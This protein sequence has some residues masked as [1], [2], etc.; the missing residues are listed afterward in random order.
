[1]AVFDANLLVALAVKAPWSAKARELLIQ[2]PKP[3]APAFLQIE[4]ANAL[5]R[6]VREGAI[7]PVDAIHAVRAIPAL[8]HL[9][10]DAPLAEPALQI[11]IAAK[12]PVYDCL[13]L[14]LA[15][16]EGGPLVTADRRLSH[17]ATAR[18][19]EATLVID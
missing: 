2:D 13:Y 5:W 17:I 19:V 9:E 1:M 10:A 4:L 14:A 16:R 18:G 11:A 12:H 6:N 7:S 3:I 8:L 15:E